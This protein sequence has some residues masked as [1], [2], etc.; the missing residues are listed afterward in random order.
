MGKYNGKYKIS[1]HAYWELYHFCLRYWEFKKKIDEIM[2]SGGGNGVVTYSETS[3]RYSDPT[4]NKAIKLE[5]LNRN[6]ELIEQTAMET[7]GNIYQPLFNNIT[8]GV[9][10]D[11][12]KACGIKIL[13]GRRQFY[14]KRKKFFWLLEQKHAAK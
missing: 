5:P 9:T 14:N 3:G 6:C 2:L 4:A 1:D 11:Q 7:D 13:C 10:Y 12:M 8:T